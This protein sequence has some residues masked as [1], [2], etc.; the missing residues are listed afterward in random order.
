MIDVFNEQLIDLRAACR[1]PAF[2]NPRTK[3]G[4]HVSQAYRWITRGA[5]AVDGQR[6]RLEVIKTPS[7]MRTSREAIARFISKLST[8]SPLTPEASLSTRRRQQVE[9]A[10]RELHE[11]GVL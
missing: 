1:L 7:G 5:R 11:A 9:C 6:V 2:R 3:R 8:P 4:A 10:V